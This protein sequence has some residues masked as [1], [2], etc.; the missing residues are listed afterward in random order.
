MKKMLSPLIVFTKHL[1]PLPLSVLAQKLAELGAKGADLCVRS[2]YPVNPDNIK[3]KLPE[4]CRIFQEEGLVIPL[5]TTP[6]DFTD[7]EKP[8]TEKFLAA[9]GEAGV[10][11]VKL[12]YWV[13]QDNGYW[14]TVEQIRKK[15][16]VFSRLA[17]KHRVKVLIHNHSG[18]TMGLN[19]C[20]AMNLVKG[21]DPRYVGIFAD[22]GHLS[23]VGE[24]LSMALDIIAEYWSALALKDII[25][26]RVLVENRLEWRLRV[27]PLGEGYTDWLTLA[28]ILKDKNFT[29]PISFHSEYSELEIDSVIDQT[30]MDLRFFKKLLTTVS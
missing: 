17:E 24:P 14:K 3:R 7:P 10:P 25:R 4:A 8:E 28:R 9:T 20:S 19:S 26:Q 6:G 15:L 12:G 11:L 21:F 18:E 27:V 29:G 5:V 2:G 13:R 22:T 23:I 16:E 1:Q 30:R